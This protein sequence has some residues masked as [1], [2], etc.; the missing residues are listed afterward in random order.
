VAVWRQA[1]IITSVAD[2]AQVSRPNRPKL[3]GNVALAVQPLGIDVGKLW[4]GFPSSIAHLANQVC[5]QLKL[6]GNFS[7]ENVPLIERRYVGERYGNASL[8]GMRAIRT[9][10]SL[11]GLLLDPIYT[12]KA[13]A[14]LLDL[15]EQGKID[16]NKSLIFLHTGGLPG[17][18]AFDNEQF[19]F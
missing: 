1:R 19:D 16:A 18:F 15:L 8:E 17:L 11:E 2:A 12:G 6:P 4:S 14:G 10:A 13:F 3:G 7:P 9:L 5:Q